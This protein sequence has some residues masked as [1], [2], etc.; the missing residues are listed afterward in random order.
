MKKTIIN[1]STSGITIEV[2]GIPKGEHAALRREVQELGFS[3]EIADADWFG[4]E[5]AELKGEDST[6]ELLHSLE[7]LGYEF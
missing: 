6:A 1:F 3:I 4:A 5:H 2:K 7:Y